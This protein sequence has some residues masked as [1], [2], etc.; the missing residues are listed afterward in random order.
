[1]DCNDTGLVSWEQAE[2]GELYLVLAWGANGQV[3]E[4]STTEDR[5]QL[6]G[7]HCGQLFHLTV[8]VLDGLCDN[9]RSNLSLQSGV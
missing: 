6:P 4:C 7:M 1:M 5:C 9:V 8:T 2:G 3:L